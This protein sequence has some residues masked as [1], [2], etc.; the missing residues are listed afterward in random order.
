MAVSADRS[1]DL[2][3][4]QRGPLELTSQ[5][6]QRVKFCSYLFGLTGLQRS[7]GRTGEPGHGL[8]D[9]VQSVFTHSNRRLHW[10]GRGLRS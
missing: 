3:A 8:P 7:V 4:G 9:G 1:D 5:L 2:F 6:R 10:A